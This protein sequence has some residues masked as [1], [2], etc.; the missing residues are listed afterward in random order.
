[1]PEIESAGVPQLPARLPHP[2]SGQSGRGERDWHR[3]RWIAPGL[4]APPVV[5]F[6]QLRVDTF[7]F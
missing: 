5:G 7:S 6:I 1:M 4:L 2:S 3:R